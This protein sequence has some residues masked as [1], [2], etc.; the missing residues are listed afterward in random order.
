M[1]NMRV[2]VIPIVTGALEINPKGFERMLKK[3]E[4]RGR[5]VTEQSTA[6]RLVRI[7]R[8]ILETWGDLLSLRLRWKIHSDGDTTYNWGSWYSQQ[9]DDSVIGGL[10]NKRTSGELRNYSIIKIG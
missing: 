8:R 3:L 10:G 7:L 4:I 1:Q 2:T 5:I 9:R 6:F